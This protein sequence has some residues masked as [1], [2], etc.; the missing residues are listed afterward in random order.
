MAQNDFTDF[1]GTEPQRKALEEMSQALLDKL[2]VMVAEQEARAREFALG[3]HSLSA[4]PQQ[5]ELPEIR[6]KLPELAQKV[7]PEVVQMV[8]ETV[9]AKAAAAAAAQVPEAK[10]VQAPPLV[11]QMAPPVQ[12]TPPHRRAPAAPRPVRKVEKEESSIGVSF[13]AI[14][15]FCIFVLFRSCSG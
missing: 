1:E 5:V 2:G 8:Q 9:Q 14:I 3:T 11:R 12:D 13:L 4:L 7:A 6:A 10:A 15:A